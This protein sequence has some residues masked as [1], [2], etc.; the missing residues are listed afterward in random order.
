M[1]YVKSADIARF[2]R[3]AEKVWDV[4]PG[5]PSAMADAGIARYRAWIKSL[6]LPTNLAELGAKPEDIPT[7][8][9]RLALNG[10]TLGAFRP[11]DAGDV[12]RILEACA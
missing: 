11:L 4:A 1:D 12:A 10:N 6:R 3:F 7:L 5:E 8:V 2:A 9:A